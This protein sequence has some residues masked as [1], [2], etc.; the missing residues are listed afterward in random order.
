M[1]FASAQIRDAT[2]HVSQL[3][4]MNV[5]EMVKKVKNLNRYI[6]YWWGEGIFKLLALLSVASL[7][8]RSCCNILMFC[9]VIDM[10]PCAF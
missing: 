9:N 8:D 6:K 2:F 5:L 3:T 7:D 10:P 1:V 4:K